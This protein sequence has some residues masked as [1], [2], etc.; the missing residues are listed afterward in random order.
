MKKRCSLIVASVLFAVCFINLSLLTAN[1]IEFTELST[2]LKIIIGALS[3]VSGYGASF[4]YCQSLNEKKA[5]KFMRKFL[6]LLFVFYIMILVDFTLIDDKFGRDIFKVF[7]WESSAYSDYLKSRTNF[8]P[9]ATVRLF[10]NGYI[11][12][13]LGL[14]DTVINLAGNFLIFMPLPFFLR[15]FRKK[16]LTAA[17]MLAAVVLT[18][19]SVEALQFIFLTGSCDIDDLILNTSGAMLSYY[20][21]TRKRVGLGLNRL[22][23]KVWEL[24]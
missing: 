1:L 24:L 17:R 19:V 5:Y 11:N 8:I 3:A 12:S 21:I 20:L 16:R 14:W 15:I 10:I 22:T 13:H 6:L 23:F 2:G 7:S 4:F 9:F 18:V